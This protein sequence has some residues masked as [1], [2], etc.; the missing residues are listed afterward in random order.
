MS[1]NTGQPTST[2][3]IRRLKRVKHWG[4]QWQRLT[5]QERFLLAEAFFL[6]GLGRATVLFIPFKRVAPHLGQAQQ[7]TAMG[8][9]SRIAPTV[10][11]VIALVS[12]HTPWRSNCFA[13]ALAGH[14][15]LRR[16]N[17]ANT[18]YLGVFKKEEVFTAH[19][20]L[21]NGDLI[22]TGGDIHQQY[23]VMARYGWQAPTGS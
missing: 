6:L 1:G 9:P 20:W 10:A 13:Q 18:L 8:E 7:E 17:A 19:A 14:L 21:R 11:K 12:R 2:R 3:I 23:T 15:M 5:W 22:V 4:K 16:R